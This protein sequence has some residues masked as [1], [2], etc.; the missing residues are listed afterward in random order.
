[1][2]LWPSVKDDAWASFCF[3]YS[4]NLILFGID[5][6]KL[7]NKTI[8]TFKGDNSSRASLSAGHSYIAVDSV[9]YISSHRSSN[10]V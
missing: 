1:M 2:S 9:A 7:A 3:E 6:K 5:G 10:S 4:D 8:Q